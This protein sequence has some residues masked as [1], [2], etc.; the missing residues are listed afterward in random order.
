MVDIA[1]SV[2]FLPQ[3]TNISSNSL[4]CKYCP[5]N[6]IGCDYCQEVP[7]SIING[8]KP[9]S[10]VLSHLK[11]VLRWYEY[12]GLLNHKDDKIL[13]CS[14]ADIINFPNLPELLKALKDWGFQVHLGYTSG[15]RIVNEEMVTDLINLGLDEINFSVFSTNPALRRYWMR[16]KTP[17]ESLKALK[18]LCE[19]IDVHASTVV[20]PGVID[21]GEIA[22][23][24]GVME[25]WGVKTFILSR[26]VNFK[27]EG[28]IFN[29]GPIIENIETQPYEDFV[30]LAKNIS[31]QFSIKVVG[32]PFTDPETTGTPYMLSKRKY[33]EHLNRLPEVTTDATIITSKLSLKPLKTIFEVIAPYKVNIVGVNEEIG[34]L[35]TREDLETIDLEDVKEKVIIPG[36]TLVHNKVAYEI[37]NRDGEQRDIVRGP[38]TLFYLDTECVDLQYVLEYEIKSFKGL[39]DKINHG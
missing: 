11:K 2:I 1:G 20:I 21:E 36:G 34:D 25:D 13:T 5:P 16:D 22:N 17:E 23:T 3:I 18:L 39:I 29:N 15:K 10:Q 37:F 28:L 14:C 31:N 27:R 33:R 30:E 6:K 4:G 7:D 8:F 38:T 9:V 35:I 32:S 26:F 24:C 12:L 19:N